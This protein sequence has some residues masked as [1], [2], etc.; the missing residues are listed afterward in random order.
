[1]LD[2]SN[3]FNYIGTMQRLFVIKVS[4]HGIYLAK[5]ASITSNTNVVASVLLPNAYVTGNEKIGDVLEVFLY[6]DSE[7]RIIATTQKP[8][9]QLNEIAL[10][11]IKDKNENGLFLDIGLQ[12]DIFMP[13]KSPQKYMIT[14]KII[15]RITK[16]TQQRLIAKKDITP[17]LKPCNN[18]KIL[19][20][21]LRA[22]ILSESKLGFLC[23]IMPYCYQGLIY[24]NT[25]YTNLGINQECFI[26]VTK[27][28]K[29]GKLDV[30]IERDSQQLLEYI[31]SHNAMGNYFTINDE[32]IKH[33]QMSRKGLKKELS[34]LISQHKIEF[35]KDKGYRILDSQ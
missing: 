8:L 31:Q 15:V 32:A 1:M 13:T 27:V 2:S 23:V 9:A 19:H 21:R 29:D 30:I 6:T 16:D 17:L 26:K 34:A 4:Q 12:K 35:I 7:D 5:F 10:L 20:K 25:L 22:W 18:P 11:E 28:R 14:H 24:H 33:L 3:L